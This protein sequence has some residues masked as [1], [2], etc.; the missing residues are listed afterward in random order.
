MWQCKCDCGNTIAVPSQ[1]LR[2]GKAISCG[3]QKRRTKD[4]TG[5]HFGRL[6]LLEKTNRTGKN[7]YIYKC[8][9]D[10]GNIIYRPI[11]LIKSGGIKSCG[12]LAQ[13]MNKEKIKRMR[14]ANHVEGTAVGNIASRKLAKNNTSGHTGVARSGD[15]WKAQ[16]TFKGVHYYLGSSKDKNEAIRAREAAEKELFGT[17]L[18]WYAENYPKQWERIKNKKPRN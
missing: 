17:F 7:G 8:Q 4:Y 3:C 5:L 10:C 14:E 13:N 6:T 9:C 15:Y 11:S 16:I 18:K 12:C 1:S 2:N